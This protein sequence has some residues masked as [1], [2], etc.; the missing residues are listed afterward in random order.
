MDSIVG[1]YGNTKE[2]NYLYNSLKEEDLIQK[3]SIFLEECNLVI[4]S[5][6]KYVND[7]K[8]FLITYGDIYNINSLK[9]DFKLK[10][11]DN[12]NE[13]ILSLYNYFL[14]N[15]DSIDAIKNIMLHLDGEYSFVLCDD[16]NLIL[17]RDSIGL[18][19]IYYGFKDNIFVFASSRKVLWHW[20]IKDIKTLI[21][22]HILVINKINPNNYKLIFFED[23]CDKNS[24][25]YDTHY[26][27]NNLKNQLKNNL[28]AATKKRI[29][30]TQDIAIIFSG[31]VD[32]TL[33]TK[34]VQNQNKNIKLYT[35]GTNNSKDL[36]FAKCAANLLNLDLEEIIIDKYVIEE[37]L[38]EVIT[39][40]E[41]FNVMKIG[42]AMPL[43][44]ASKRANED[45]FNI[46]VSGQGADELF[47]GY[48]KYLKNYIKL[49]SKTQDILYDDIK[50]S[51]HVNLERDNAIT[52]FNNISLKAPFMDKTMINLAMKI[53]IKYKIKSNDDQ[54]RK[55][56]LR[57]VAI[58]LGVPEFIAM[59]PK[60]AAQYGSGVH[61]L[62]IKKILP[63]FDERTFMDTL[64]KPRI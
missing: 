17:T 29:N 45:G 48:T 53:P 59:R 47:G 46:A 5:N 20:G 24:I 22:G 35:V 3:M 9:E 61:K 63:N 55:H 8:Q 44:I 52:N 16:N 14:E 43:H 12:P 56:I 18:K 62:L 27:Y 57:D 6:L 60:K 28:I 2:I 50:N 39:T 51:Y 40:I 7:S 37:N 31:G 42:V 58:E 13:I 64:R 23:I 11:T 15:N 26:T 30:N 25:C 32:S 19:P 54:I 36:K 34:I 1:V 33:I 49:N 4:D 21:P 10:D 38:E 41:E